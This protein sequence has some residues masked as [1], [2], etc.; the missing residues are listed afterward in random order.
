MEI[1]R[2]AAAVAPLRD[3]RSGRWSRRWRPRGKMPPCS[4]AQAETLRIR[5]AALQG[6]L[7]AWKER[8][9]FMEGTRA[10]RLRQVLV[11]L[12]RRFFGPGAGRG[13]EEH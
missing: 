13:S 2:L 6:E 12:K 11:G 1:D 5:I 10:W 3:E 8:V 4:K 7:A 9:G